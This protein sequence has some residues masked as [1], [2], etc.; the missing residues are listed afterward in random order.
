MTPAAMTTVDLLEHAA[1]V[2]D[3]WGDECD[4][5]AAAELRA[6]A[7]WMRDEIA[8]VD[9]ILSLA[10]PINIELGRHAWAVGKR[11]ALTSVNRPTRLARRPRTPGAGK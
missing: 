10:D 5:K 3:G 4:R 6:R 7:E 2:L 11:D 8:G 1:R 9:K